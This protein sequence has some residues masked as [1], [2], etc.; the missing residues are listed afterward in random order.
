[1][2]PVIESIQNNSNQSFKLSIYDKGA[3]PCDADYW[4]IHPEYEIVYIHNG[5]GPR[6]V[7]SHVS[8]YSDG[9]LLLL[10]PNLPHLP[11]GNQ[12]YP[13]NFE[14]V[15]QFS[16][17]FFWD[18]VA[19]FPEC[20]SLIELKNRCLQGLA[21]GAATRQKV[22]SYIRPAANATELEKLL[23]LL[24]LLHDLAHANDATSLQA[25]PVHT[26][27]KQA[28]YD[29]LKIILSQIVNNY[30]QEI[31]LDQLAADVGLTKNS[32]CRFFKKLTGQSILEYL[33]TYRLEIAKQLLVRQELSIAEVVYQSGFNDPSFFYKKFRAFTGLSPK[34]FQQ[35]GKA[36]MC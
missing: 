4:H 2:R 34:A 30:S 9:E 27:Q 10:G 35:N 29:R 3:P 20:K 5:S 24:R 18:K 21:F 31:S 33:T 19:A 22:S 7:G 11:L 12:L 8:N 28:D 13:D 26:E 17:V 1:M 25:Y 6:H 36:S 14:V 16:E 23:W 15:V 32:L